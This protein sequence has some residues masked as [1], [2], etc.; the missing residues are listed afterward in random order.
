MNRYIDKKDIYLPLRNPLKNI[1]LKNGQFLRRDNQFEFLMFC[2]LV[3]L[4]GRLF[5]EGIKKDQEVVMAEVHNLRMF[6]YVGP[7]V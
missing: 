1:F 3:I 2:I 6:F 5:Y 7:R 4:M